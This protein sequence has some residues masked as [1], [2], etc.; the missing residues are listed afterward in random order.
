MKRAANNDWS[1]NFILS[2]ISFK[3]KTYKSKENYIKS[4]K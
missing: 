2:T 4:C 3:R 1:W